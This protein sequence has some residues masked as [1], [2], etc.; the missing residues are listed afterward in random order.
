MYSSLSIRRLPHS[1]RKQVINAICGKHKIFADLNDTKEARII[2]AGN[3]ATRD[4]GTTDG[5]GSGGMIHALP[6]TVQKNVT[7]DLTDTAEARG[8]SGTQ[9]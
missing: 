5:N 1:R 2:W 7:S 4:V 6:R 8:K 9:Q 3:S